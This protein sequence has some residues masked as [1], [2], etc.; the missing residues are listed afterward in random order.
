VKQLKFL[1]VCQ[2]GHSRSA[3]MAMVWHKLGHQA[4]A[5]GVRTSPSALDHLSDWADWICLMQPNFADWVQNRH[6]SA[7][8]DFNVGAD[9]WANPYNEELH[10]MLEPMA[11]RFLNDLKRNHL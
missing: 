9:I 10:A 1:C 7:V 3:A 2:Y 11:V 8:V 6:K 4:V 5:V